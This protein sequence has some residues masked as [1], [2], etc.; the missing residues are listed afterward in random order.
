MTTTPLGHPITVKEWHV[1]LIGNPN[2]G[3]TTLFNALTGLHQR[4]GNYPGITVE[5]KEG[6][7][8]LGEQKVSLLDLPGTYSLA[9]SSPDE[10]VV[11]E[12]LL[13]DAQ[14]ETP[15]D[16]LILV[17]DASNLTR[18]LFLGA[19]IADLE[20]PLLVVLNLWDES[21]KKGI[22][23]D[24]ELL[25][26]R[27]GVPVVATIAKK[28]VGIEDVRNALKQVLI[29]TPSMHRYGWPK[30]VEEAVW[31][32]RSGLQSNHRITDTA[33]RRLLFDA[34][35]LQSPLREQLGWNDETL[36]LHMQTARRHLLKSGLNPLAAESLLLYKHIGTLL[37][38]V[39][40]MPDGYVTSHTESI[41]RMMIHR[42]WGLLIFVGMMY[43]VF[44]SVY[45]WASPFMDLIGSLISGLQQIVSAPL[46]TSPMLQSLVTDGIIGGVGAFLVFLPQIMI[47]FF[48]ISLLEDTGYMARAA[49]LMDKLFSW[50]GLNGKS[51]VPML[52]SYACAIPGV[53]AARTIQDPKARIV[54][55]L[56]APLMSCSARLPVYI[57]LIGAFIQPIYGAWWAG[58]ALFAMHFVG[59]IIAIP[60][61]WIM[62]RWIFRTPSQPFIMELPPYRIPR[63]RD[64]FMRMWLRGQDF[65]K[66]A[67]T[68]IFA[69]TIIVW[70]LLYFPRPE[71]VSDNVTE[72]FIAEQAE[73][74][75]TDRFS[76]ET[77]LQ[78]L[79]SPLRNELE[80]RINATLINQSFM[81]RMGHFFQ[82]LFDP[83]GFDWKITIG[84][85]ASIPARE[86]IIS[87]LGIIY[88]LGTDVDETSNDLRT[89]MLKERWPE[90][91]PRAGQPVYTIPVAAGIMVFFALCLQCG[92]TIAIIYRELN[93][94][95]ALS[96]FVYMTILAWLGAVVTYQVGM[97]FLA[98]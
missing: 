45:S 56:I 81:G 18:N 20:I 94:K 39:I 89:I 36:K 51:F 2:T 27:L 11:V 47:L 88:S 90:G 53:M 22:R 96:G 63:F 64:I 37:E 31:E 66:T 26:R 75:G 70:A 13:G 67:G 5:K 38:G 60:V 83:A 25:S 73:A 69:L 41:D 49:F 79:D 84:V 57:L 54:T 24:L 14:R 61:S 44:Q 59:L 74:T 62:N 21:I 42:G 43:V 28:D 97:Y 19:Q 17:V 33:L 46:A 65:I 76:I 55:T 40:G 92:A 87:T 3:K 34:Q 98:A 35:P 72:H 52:T 93:W 29:E 23:I 15:L 30:C 95:Y 4:V 91:T 50:C 82:P 1:G 10:R 6:W 80:N 7:F 12:T 78:G 48:F 16:A 71:S 8:Q 9:A 85:L 32:L 58:F 68:I 77:A 86:V